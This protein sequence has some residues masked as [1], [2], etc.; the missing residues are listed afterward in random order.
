ML[1]QRSD[2]DFTNAWRALGYVRCETADSAPSVPEELDAVMEHPPPPPLPPLRVVNIHALTGWYVTLPLPLFAP[3]PQVFA[4]GSV[5][6]ALRAEWQRWL[7]AYQSRVRDG[8]DVLTRVGRSEEACD[9][10]RKAQQ[11]TVNPRIV[12]RN[13]HV[14]RGTQLRRLH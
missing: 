4:H 3:L 11:H 2:C 5:D 8:Y 6:D 14:R 13:Y 1:M 9:D 7:V 10:A 12:P